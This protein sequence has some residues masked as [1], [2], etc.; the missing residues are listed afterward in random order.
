MV[1]VSSGF[2]LDSF[3]LYRFIWSFLSCDARFPDSG[4]TRCKAARSRLVALV[5]FLVLTEW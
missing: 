4:C 1:S 5:A 3:L 2:V